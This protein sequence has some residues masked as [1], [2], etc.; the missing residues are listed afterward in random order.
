MFRKWWRYGRDPKGTGVIVP[1][2]DA[3]DGLT[4][5]EVA[6]VDFA[7]VS[8]SHISAE[9]IYLATEGY[10]KIEKIEGH[11]I[12]GH[13]DY[14][15]TKIKPLPNDAVICDSTLLNFLMLKDEP[16]DSVLISDLKNEF[17]ANIPAINDSVFNQL[18]T[19]GYFPDTPSNMNKMYTGRGLALL[20]GG[21]VLAF[22]LPISW[23]IFVAIALSGGV[24]F[25]LG[26][27]MS[28][29]TLKG[30]Q[31]REYILGFKE[32]LQIAEKD[33]INFANAPEKKPEIFEK[34]LPYAMVLGVEKAWAKEFE[35]I[36]T[37]PPSWYSDPHM[38]AFST[39]LFVG[40]LGNFR[41]STSSSLSSSPGSSGGGFAGGGGGGGGGGSW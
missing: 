28:H 12:F 2:Y 26:S 40:S 9:I 37:T 13:D 15:I 10:L 24:I 32:Y 39:G 36:Y 14:R 35:G 25:G 33:R 19:K 31:T 1:Q 7:L 27:F 20:I 23:E 17:Y 29:R 34:L 6:G 8:S 18:V 11:G 22:F 5:M 30:V 21:G 3:P 38:N 41:S 4:P 16:E